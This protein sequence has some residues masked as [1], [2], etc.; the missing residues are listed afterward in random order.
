MLYF[1]CTYYPLI[2]DE[3]NKT[4]GG[5]IRFFNGAYKLAKH[6][7]EV[8]IENNLIDKNNGNIEFYDSNYSEQK[9]KRFFDIIGNTCQNPTKNVII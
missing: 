6:L 7:Q 1:G 3:I 8:L 9:K 4:L 2:E 5:N